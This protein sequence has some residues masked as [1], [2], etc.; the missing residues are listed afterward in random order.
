MKQ[1]WKSKESLEFTATQGLNRSEGVD[2]EE[3]ICSFP[4]LD[5]RDSSRLTDF[6]C[7]NQVV[8]FRDRDRL[9]YSRSSYWIWVARC[10]DTFVIEAKDSA[11]L[12]IS[13]CQGTFI[14]SKDSSPLED[15]WNEK[16]AES[17]VQRSPWSHSKDLRNKMHI[18][19]WRSGGNACIVEAEDRIA[20]STLS[21]TSAKMNRDRL[22]W[23]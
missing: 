15:L 22:T 14:E 2:D 20:L 19:K 13:R 10:P 8:D 4:F 3:S 1:L 23:W 21:W 11:R 18:M 7:P 9:K 12:G 5:S 6:M 16:E 17:L